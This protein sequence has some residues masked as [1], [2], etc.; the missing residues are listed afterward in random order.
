MRYE[1]T[2]LSLTDQ[3]D[4]LKS[5]GLKFDDETL[6]K[7]T[8]SNISY[9]RLRAY[10][11]P[12]QNNNEDSHLFVTSVT[13]EKIIEL[14]VFDSQ[15]R[16]LVFEALEK[17]EIALRTQIVYEM[18]MAYGSHWMIQ[19]NHFKNSCFYRSNLNSINEEIGRSKETFIDHYKQKY[20]EPELPPSW[21]SLEVVS[22]GLLSQILS[23]IRPYQPRRNIQKKLGHKRDDIFISWIHAFVGLRNICAHHGRLWNRRLTLRPTLP[24]NT[25]FQFLDKTDVS[26]NKLY[27]ILSCLNYTLRF[28]H[29]GSDWIGRVKAHIVSCPLAKLKH[30]GFPKEW[31]SE[32]LWNCQNDFK[33]IIKK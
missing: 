30:M 33:P 21:M 2:P 15:L 31:E 11:Y 20:N 32:P 18:S 12:F 14:Y 10:T 16:R 9:Y 23:N 28:T 3:I 17:I 8:L 25:P 29:P 19:E 13:F 1:K 7:Q 26:N 27:A 5:R 6:A 24:Y 22:M 4:R